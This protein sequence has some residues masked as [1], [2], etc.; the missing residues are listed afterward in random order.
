[1]VVRTGHNARVATTARE[2]LLGTVRID[3]HRLLPWAALRVG[4][5]VTVLVFACVSTGNQALALPVAVGALF[6]ALSDAGE[7]VGRRWRTMLWTT[8]WITVTT[9]LG[10]IGSNHVV[11]GLVLAI[12][13]ALV[14]GLAG[15]LG[16]RG[17]LVGLLALV[18]FTVFNGAPESHRSIVQSA[19]L[20]GAGGFIMTVVTVVPRMFQDRFW[21]LAR[22]PVEP[23]RDRLRGQFTMR[24]DFVRHAVRLAVVIGLA[25]LLVD[26][27][28]YPHDYWLPMTVAWVTKPDRDGTANRIIE[29]IAGTIGGVLLAAYLIDVLNW[30]DVEVALIAGAA[31]AL[32]VGFIAANYSVAVVGVTLLVVG[33]FTFDGDPVAAT[34]V[35]RII[36]TIAAGVMAFLGFYIWPPARPRA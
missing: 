14:A 18:S 26:I 10:G 35:G 7:D 28:S 11:L 30:N 23:L 6:A 12:A 2:L 19:L 24:N 36:A 25:T 13:I 20:M 9:A 32:A 1:M 5:V 22:T 17:A 31:A 27:T 16:P 15:M 34:L 4:L 29:R 33:L 21:R 3:K 8:L